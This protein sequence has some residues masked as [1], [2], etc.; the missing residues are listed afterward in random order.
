VR[1]LVPGCGRGHEVLLLARLGH[2]VLGLDVAAPA[3][4]ALRA[5]RRR[6]R[7]PASRCRTARADFLALPRRLEGAFD[8]LVEHTCFC[9]IDPALRPVYVESAARALVP[10]G[11]LVG[12][13]YPFRE[14]EGGPPFRVTE[15]EVR[16]LF[17]P[18]FDVDS[19]ETPTTSI[20]RRRGE[21]RLVVMT[22]RDA[23]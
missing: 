18:R 3:L 6:D 10:G 5:A 4:A 11:R 19:W 15:R 17:A 14:R 9:A 16:A 2:R 23:R 22:R 12:L 8:L 13:F 7:V 20:D 21:E 1:V